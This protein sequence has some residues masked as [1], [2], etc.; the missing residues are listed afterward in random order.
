MVKTHLGPCLYWSRKL[1]LKIYRPGPRTKS[2]S[3]RP[4]KKK[5]KESFLDQWIFAFHQHQ[6]RGEQEYGVITPK[7]FWKFKRKNPTNLC[8]VIFIWFWW[9]VVRHVNFYCNRRFGTFIFRSRMVIISF[10]K[11]FEETFLSFF[12]KWWIDKVLS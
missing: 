10:W 8:I 6:I 1:D 7:N 5:K 9:F 12:L 3:S 2:L 11:L 4:S